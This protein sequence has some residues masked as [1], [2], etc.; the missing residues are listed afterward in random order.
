MV[1]V[2]W[3]GRL[4]IDPD[5]LFHMIILVGFVRYTCVGM[6]GKKAVTDAF[7]LAGY[8]A[9]AYEMDQDSVCEDILSPPGFAYAL[10]LILR[11]EPG[12]A[13]WC[14]QSDHSLPWLTYIPKNNQMVCE[15]NR[16]AKLAELWPLE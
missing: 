12:S 16:D 2:W 9:L 6:A 7:A 4:V 5:N 8:S 13:V 3:A 1:G 15:T 14:W 10:S 11:L